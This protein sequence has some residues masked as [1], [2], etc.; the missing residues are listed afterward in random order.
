MVNQKEHHLKYEYLI[1]DLDG[2][3]SD[4]QEGITKSLN[5]ALTSHDLPAQDTD[6]LANFIGPPLERIFEQVT[7]SKDPALILSLVNKY[8]ER[9]ADVGYAE[10]VVYD[11]IPEMLAQLSTIPNLKLGVCT[12]K[13]VDFAKRILD[14]FDLS[15]YFQFVDGGDVGIAK[16]QQL[17]TLLQQKT[18]TQNSVMIG[19]RYIDITAGQKNELS[20]A[21]V[22]WGFGSHKEL[23]TLN[24]THLFQTPS[25]LEVLI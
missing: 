9:Y 17:E 20:T 7:E 23:S 13:R 4:P 2:T 14:L 19:D 5:Y 3:L 1:F 18:I 16:W 10:N 25:E 21:G 6:Y 22:L 24:P 15:Q 11:G 8:R 12:S